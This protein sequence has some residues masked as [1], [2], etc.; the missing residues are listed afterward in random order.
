MPRYSPVSI[1][2]I[3]RNEEKNLPR[4][5][6]S[7]LNLNYPREKLEIIYVDND[8]TD[9]SM[10]VAKDYIPHIYSVS[11]DWPT[12]GLARNKG[13]IEAK[14]E[15]IHFLDGDIEIDP[16][17]LWQAVQIFEEKQCEAVF[18]YLKEKNKG[19]NRV[20]LSHW[21]DKE[22]GYVNTSGG[23]GTYKKAP[24]LQI[25]GY[26]ERIRKGQEI[27]MGE[28][29]LKNGYK[30]WFAKIPMGIHDYNVKSVSSFFNIPFIMGKSVFYN[31]LIK[32]NNT[33]FIRKQKKNNIKY[34]LL[35]C[36]F[37]LSIVFCFLYSCIPLII[38]L[39]FFLFRLVRMIKN[40][41]PFKTFN[42]FIFTLIR[43]IYL[44]IF[45]IGQLQIFRKICISRTISFPDKKCIID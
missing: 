29:F 23:G 9:R 6:T 41:Y 44:F 34:I 26:D 15:I 35:N 36:C 33:D 13:L 21:D 11:S 18:G 37:Y 8:S 40:N 17:Y 16:D 28:R 39:G 45:F 19:I 1:V 20:L 14:Y 12:P 25:N 10:E 27:E 31:S 22:E 43:S 30:I 3:G 5:L 38:F 4:V 7:C 42:S 2:V 32:D 24:L